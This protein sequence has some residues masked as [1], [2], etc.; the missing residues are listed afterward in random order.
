[1]NN[2]KHPLTDKQLDQMADDS[3]DN[4]RA[5]IETGIEV[6]DRGFSRDPN[7]VIRV[8]WAV[9]ASAAI[10]E[11]MR[12]R[13][14]ALCKGDTTKI[15]MVHVSAAEGRKLGVAITASEQA[16]EVMKA[17]VDGA[18]RE[19]QKMKEAGLC[20]CFACFCEQMGLPAPAKGDIS[21]D[22]RGLIAQV[23][24]RKPNDGRTGN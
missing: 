19:A 2:K 12:A 8:L 14:E 4:I 6:M 22:V 21:N 15:G 18:M 16:A 17:A 3:V 1:M 10:A 24:C 5:A 13:A 20:E 11:V 7:E 23:Q 9:V